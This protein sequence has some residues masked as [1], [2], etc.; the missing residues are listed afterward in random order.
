MD[1]ER[2]YKRV[3]HNAILPKFFC[4]IVRS[5]QKTKAML[6]HIKFVGEVLT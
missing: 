4:R 5:V 1:P 3:K 2:L 6:K